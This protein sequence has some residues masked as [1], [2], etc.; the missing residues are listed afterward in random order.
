MNVDKVRCFAWNASRV[1]QSIAGGL[2][3]T[4]QCVNVGR[5]AHANQGGIDTGKNVTAGVTVCCGH[6]WFV[7]VDLGVVNRQATLTIS[8]ANTARVAVQLTAKGAVNA[9]QPVA[10]ADPTAVQLRG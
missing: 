6:D 4:A 9:A 5:Q 8:K 7:K 10:A 3:R 1:H 2:E